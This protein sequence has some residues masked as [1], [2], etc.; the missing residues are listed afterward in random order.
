MIKVDI[1]SYGKEIKFLNILQK[2]DEKKGNP[3][4]PPPIVFL[5]GACLVFSPV[6]VLDG[7]INSKI[8]AIFFF[9]LLP[10]KV[11]D[12]FILSASFCHWQLT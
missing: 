1:D 3:P 12:H 4:H 9:S 7:E 5:L 11:K 6:V 10:P 2:K 8:L